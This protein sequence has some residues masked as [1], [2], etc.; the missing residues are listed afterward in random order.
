MLEELSK[1][2]AGTGPREIA[3]ATGVDRSAA[4]RV[5]SALRDTGFASQETEFGPYVPG[6]RLKALAMR[7]RAHD[8]TGS[9]ARPIVQRLR[10]DVDETV[11]FITSRIGDEQHLIVAE[12]SR[13]IRFSVVEGT[14]ATE[15][16][17][18]AGELRGD[19]VSV[20]DDLDSVR[21]IAPIGVGHPELSDL[22]MV[23]IP[24]ARATEQSVRDVSHAIHAAAREL[25]GLL[26]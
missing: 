19:H 10:D 24:H 12:S 7:L 15:D 20:I 2:P 16:L 9:V 1:H 4:S 13:R 11:S 3:R 6:V 14:S 22:L 18:G 17:R 8:G 25:R 21:L 26:P 5:L 23:V